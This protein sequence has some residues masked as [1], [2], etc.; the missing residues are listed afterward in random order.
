MSFFLQKLFNIIHVGC[1]VYFTL[2]S[3]YEFLFAEKKRQINIEQ[4]TNYIAFKKVK[5]N[6]EVVRFR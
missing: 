4:I 3:L 1:V 6:G 2:K 5:L